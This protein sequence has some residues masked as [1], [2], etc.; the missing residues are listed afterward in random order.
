MYSHKDPLLPLIWALELPTQIHFCTQLRMTKFFR[1][2][3]LKAAVEEKVWFWCQLINQDYHQII[4]FLIANTTSENKIEQE[5]QKSKKFQQEST[6]LRKHIMLSCDT[7]AGNKSLVKSR[8]P[9]AH[10]KW[11]KWY[12]KMM[13]DGQ[14]FKHLSEI[15]MTQ[16]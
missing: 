13:S 15:E 11:L 8:D 4:R 5:T 9:S 7:L 12:L 2:L 14:S 16:E 10:T 6:K 1:R 3:K